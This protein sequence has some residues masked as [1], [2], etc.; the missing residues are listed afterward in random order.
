MG[1]A[2]FDH[3]HHSAVINTRQYRAPEVILGCLKWDKT[4]DIWGMACIVIELITGIRKKLSRGT[5]LPDKK[6]RL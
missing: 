4:S 1:G 3:E 5:L 2:T 6:K